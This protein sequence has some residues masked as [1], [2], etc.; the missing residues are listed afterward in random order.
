MVKS[1]AQ[2]IRDMGNR[3][4]QING[5]DEPS[6]P[7][8]PAPAAVP[9]SVPVPPPGPTTPPPSMVAMNSGAMEHAAPT[10]VQD[11]FEEPSYP[12]LF[13]AYNPGVK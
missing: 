12:P 10:K 9:P 6:V 7:V 1:V 2:E 8:T 5:L 13:Q 4:A 11:W 3:L